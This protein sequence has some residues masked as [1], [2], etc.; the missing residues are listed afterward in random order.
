MLYFPAHKF[1]GAM[2]IE[3]LW[4]RQEEER[5]CLRANAGAKAQADRLH[6]SEEQMRACF[7]SGRNESLGLALFERDEKAPVIVV[8]IRAAYDRLV[9]IWVIAERGMNQDRQPI[10][11]AAIG[12]RKLR[13]STVPTFLAEFLRLAG[14]LG[15]SRNHLRDRG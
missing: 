7:G 4:G 1:S 10:V 3:E 12:V 2:G 8:G 15:R 6:S 11:P 9:D 5:E 14:L 13:Y